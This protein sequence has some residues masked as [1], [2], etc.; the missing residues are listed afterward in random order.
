MSDRQCI[1]CFVAAE[2]VLGI[3][4]LLNSIRFSGITHDFVVLASP[5]I[6]KQVRERFRS[7]GAIVQEIQNIN[8]PYMHVSNRFGHTLNKLHL[9]NLTAYDRVV[10]LDAD[11]LVLDKRMDELFSCGH[12]CAV[13]MNPFHFHTGLLVVKPSIR[14]Y[15]T[16][17]DSVGVIDSYDGVPSCST[18]SKLLYSAMLHFH[19]G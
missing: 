17:L 14:M 7:E 9:W 12:F 8:N 10:Y 19:A 5:H 2:Y 1:D 16:L 15:H 3:S 4:V 18:C 13:Y 11:N 6:R